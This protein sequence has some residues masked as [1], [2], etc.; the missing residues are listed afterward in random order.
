[1]E[2]RFLRRTWAEIDLDA[3]AE[4]CRQIQKTLSPGC[5]MIAVVK[6]DAYGHGAVTCARLLR[7]QGVSYFAVS[8]VEEAVQLR[9]GGI[10]ESILILS[11]TP[12]DEAVRLAAL[13][14]TQTVISREY[15]LRL[16]EAAV[17]A[18]VTVRIHVKVDTGMSRV[19]FFYQSSC[20]ETV[21]DIAEICRLPAF[22]PEGIFT[23]FAVADEPESDTYTHR[24]FAL[25]MEVL[26]QL[27]AQ[28]IAFAMRHCCNSAATLR[29]P[30]MHLDAVR[31]GLILYGLSPTAA[32][33]AAPLH[34]VMTVKATVTQVKT[35]PAGTSVSYGCTHRTETDTVLATV[36]VGYGDGFPRALSNRWSMRIQGTPA[37]LRGRVCM[38]QCMLDIS[39]IPGVAAGDTVT[40]MGGTGFCSVE[41]LATATDTITYEAV[42]HLSKR[43]PRIFRQNGTVVDQLNYLVPKP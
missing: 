9:Q 43:V 13:N 20:E 25:F 10:T 40:V 11:H 26:Q 39:H 36:P 37:P 32:P 29:F 34:P 33:Y 28:G 41:A 1:M 5:R 15:G 38:D 7:E 31:P 22:T 16:H 4:N 12:P 23:H 24:Q 17:A 35:V 8:N 14:I 3:L 6:A 27:Q 19:G 30:E 42:C 21:A 2:N 18:G